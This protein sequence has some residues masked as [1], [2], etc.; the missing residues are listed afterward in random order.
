[1]GKGYNVDLFKID[2]PFL[3]TPAGYYRIAHHKLT[4]D[5]SEIFCG[6]VGHAPHG[7][8]PLTD[9]E[10]DMSSGYG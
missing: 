1:M 9:S 10:R 4:H 7:V 5:L 3:E 8:I 6:F 2:T